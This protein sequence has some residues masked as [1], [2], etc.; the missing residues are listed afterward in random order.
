MDIET[1]P[2][3]ASAVARRAVAPLDALRLP[4]S[5]VAKAILTG[6]EPECGGVKSGVLVQRDGMQ[7]MF[8]AKDASTAAAVVAASEHGKE[9]WARGVVAGRGRRVRLLR[10][11]QLA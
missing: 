7:R 3:R 6:T 2:L 5:V 8:G 4:N 1:A 9:A 11:Y 10:T